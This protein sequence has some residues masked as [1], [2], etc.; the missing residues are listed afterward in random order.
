MTNPL[1]RLFFF[2]FITLS[3]FGESPVVLASNFQAINPPQNQVIQQSYRLQ[4]RARNR[5]VPIEVYV[6]HLSQRKA[7]DKHYNLPVVI[8]NHGYGVRNTEYS[9]LAKELAAQGYYV[10]SIQHDLKTDPPLARTGDL[11]ARRKPLWKR[12]VLNILF[13]MSELHRIQSNLN[14]NKIIL[15]GHSNGGDIA[16]LFAREHPRLVEKLISLD[17]LRMPFPRNAISPI[18]SLRANDTQADTGVLPNDKEAKQLGIVIIKLEKSKH[19]DLCDRGGV[20]THKKINQFTFKFLNNSFT[21][22]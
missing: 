7:K 16:M 14:I 9:F 2:L 13:V 19:I 11:F 8:I 15:I 12:G 22:L 20:K 5:V 3:C 18:L 6:S 4:D 10:V 17:S 21:S 1:C